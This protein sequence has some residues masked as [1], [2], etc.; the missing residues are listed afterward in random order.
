LSIRKNQ[1]HQI[2]EDFIFLASNQLEKR[3]TGTEREKT[4]DFKVGLKV[5]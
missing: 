2:K 4:P 5:S 3:Q 1:E